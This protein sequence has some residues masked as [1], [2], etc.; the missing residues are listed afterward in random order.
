MDESQNRNL[1][2]RESITDKLKARLPL[3]VGVLAMILVGVAIYGVIYK[4]IFHSNV[5]STLS[6]TPIDKNVIETFAPNKTLPGFPS[7]IPTPASATITRNIKL[8]T[9]E[10]RIQLTR[11]LTSSKS[12]KEVYDFY[13]SSLTSSSAWKILNKFDD[14]KSPNI[15]AVLAQGSEGTLTVSIRYNSVT[16]LT[17][18]D[19][20]LTLAK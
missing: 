4:G 5:S 19:L 10:G 9:P 18:I 6:P 13:V 2:G 16:K 17:D 7:N 14:P 3:I 12:I 11:Q 1:D 15:K 20:S 8:T